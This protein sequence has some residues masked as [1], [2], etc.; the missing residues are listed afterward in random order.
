MCILYYRVMLIALLIA[1]AFSKY[2]LEGLHWKKLFAL[3]VLAQVC[4]HT[5]STN[6]HKHTLKH[7]HSYTCTYEW[8]YIIT[9][10]SCVFCA[11][12]RRK[13]SRAINIAFSRA[14]C[15]H[16]SYR[17]VTFGV[18]YCVL[19]WLI[20]WNICS[21]LHIHTNTHRS[22]G[23]LTTHTNNQMHTHRGIAHLLSAFI[24]QRIA[25]AAHTV[26]FCQNLTDWT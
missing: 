3:F 5:P 11:T 16:T 21:H 8:I 2:S 18:A 19:Y 25:L 13:A 12:G 1:I 6:S 10:F 20:V 26:R 23:S 24:M 7:I 15:V 4:I 14:V 9:S 17:V 22:T